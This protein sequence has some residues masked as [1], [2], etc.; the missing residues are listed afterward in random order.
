MKFIFKFIIILLFSLELF[1]QRDCALYSKDILQ[2]KVNSKIFTITQAFWKTDEE[3]NNYRNYLC[4]AWNIDVEIFECN[5][6]SK[7]NA[8]FEWSPKYIN[9]GNHY[10]HLYD[11]PSGKYKLNCDSDSKEF[12]FTEFTF[13]VHVNINR[14]YKHQEKLFLQFKVAEKKEIDIIQKEDIK[15]L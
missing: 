1:S 10:F 13:V 4:L 7:N 8:I 9:Y 2:S 15:V 3:F 12:F 14:I 11:I 6:S 5:L